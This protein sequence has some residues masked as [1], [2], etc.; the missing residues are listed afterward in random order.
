MRTVVGGGKDTAV[1]EPWE[2][3][4]HLT[5][6]GKGCLVKRKDGQIALVAVGQIYSRYFRKQK[7]VSEDFP[8][9]LSTGSISVLVL[10]KTA[11]VKHYF[12]TCEY[13]H[14]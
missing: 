7:W 11:P 14:G 1:N 12:R 4:P 6:L 3:V 5:T 2:T 13:H 8:L 10:N 9:F